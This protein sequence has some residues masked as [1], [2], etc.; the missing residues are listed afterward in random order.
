MCVSMG[1]TELLNNKDRCTDL[2]DT[3]ITYLHMSNI[4]R[5]RFNNQLQKKNILSEFIISFF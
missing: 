5:L 1:T 3:L 4:N 2:S